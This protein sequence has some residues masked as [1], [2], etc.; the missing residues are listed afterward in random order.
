MKKVLSIVLATV[1]LASLFTINAF[2]LIPAAQDKT[3]DLSTKE[4]AIAEAQTYSDVTTYK[5]F[6]AGSYANEGFEIVNEDPED[7][8]SN[9]VYEIKY[10]PVVYDEE[11]TFVSGPDHN[12][13][14]LNDGGQ[15]TNTLSTG[16]TIPATY[17]V[18]FDVCAK[19]NSTGIMFARRGAENVVQAAIGIDPDTMTVGTWYT[20]RLYIDESGYRAIVPNEGATSVTTAQANSARAAFYGNAKAFRKVRGSEADFEDVTSSLTSRTSGNAA[21]GFNLN[22]GDKNMLKD[23]IDQTAEAVGTVKNVYQEAYDACYQLDNIGIYNY[24]IPADYEIVEGVMNSFDM[25]G[26]TTSGTDVVFEAAKEED[27]NDYVKV[28]LGTDAAKAKTSS[29][30]FSTFYD[31]TTEESTPGVFTFSVD[32]NN[33]VLGAGLTFEIHGDREK[34]PYN[35][36]TEKDAYNAYEDTQTPYFARRSIMIESDASRVGQWYTYRFICKDDGTNTYTITPYRR[37]RGS[38]DEWELV[39]YEVSSQGANPAEE[40]LF[41]SAGTGSGDNRIRKWRFG[42][43]VNQLAP[44]TGENASRNTETVW[45]V[46]N[47]QFTDS[48][49][50]TGI[51]DEVDGTVTATINVAGAARASKAFVALYDGDRFVGA[52]TAFVDGEDSVVVTVDGY[53]EGYTAK[54]FVWDWEGTNVP[55]LRE[56]MDITNL[57]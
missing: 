53:Q 9:L 35:K 12:S 11:G 2:A 46:D 18:E 17:M 31:L 45:A 23:G 34:N 37:L 3:I 8:E 51:A 38:D 43:W 10:V 48:A 57:L 54:L 33:M 14:Q 5:L 24:T 55:L 41:F 7:A 16:A 28:Y 36:E 25:S 29:W 4:S 30:S 6:T 44:Y 15:G 50:V 26:R 52:G 56:A 20:Y 19:N 13:A 42:L 1:M 47:V 49:A 40:D 21:M 39:N 22:A 27:G 32:V